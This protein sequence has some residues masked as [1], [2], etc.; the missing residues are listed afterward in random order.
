M[1]LRLSIIICTL[2]RERVLC[3]TLRA[4]VVL[5]DGRDDAELLVIDQTRQHE[6][7]TEQCLNELAGK[8]QWHR[9]DFASLTRARNYG[10]RRALGDIILFLDDDVVPKPEL[11]DAHLKCYED[12][13]V[14]GVGGCTLHLDERLHSRSELSSR[15][16]RDLDSGRV[17]RFDLDWE[18]DTRWAR[19][20][21]MSFRRDRL[22]RVGGFDEAFYG[23]ALGEEVELCHRIIQ[24]G[25]R[26]RYAPKAEVLHLVNPTGGCRNAEL[27]LTR[28]T[29]VLRNSWY[30]W[31][32][33]GLPWGV[34]I[35][36]IWCAY[37]RPHVIGRS[38]CR[39]GRWLES[40]GITC[41]AVVSALREPVMQPSLGLFEKREGS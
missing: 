39:G 38:V 3:D 11:L 35:W 37:I 30:H 16:L 5:L 15:E 8:L 20:C 23:V 28:Q 36:K 27:Q 19:G 10:V 18:R 26:L 31:T 22:F 34:K 40:V 7:E 14:A 4:V 12:P 21:N 24:S 2:N 33:V 41:K 6:P 25:G 9:V 29:Q 32:R 17:D 13:D 1:S